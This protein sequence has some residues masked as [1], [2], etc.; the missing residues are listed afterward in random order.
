MSNDDITPQQLRDMAAQLL[1][2]AD[3]LEGQ[4]VGVASSPTPATVVHPDDTTT[5]RPSV[6]GPDTV[7]EWAAQ[8][9]DA[10]RA[11][12]LAFFDKIV[13]AGY[14][15]RDLAREESLA[16]RDAAEASAW[17]NGNFGLDDPRVQLQDAKAWLGAEQVR[18]QRDL[19]FVGLIGGPVAAINRYFHEADQLRLDKP[20]LAANYDGPLKD[21][22][23]RMMG[24]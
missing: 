20:W 18:R 4:P 17:V 22:L 10:A 12:A 11:A 6:Q 19:R 5:P 8:N 9:P 23:R 21:M 24:E 7:L 16:R 1:Q 15:P 13:Q 2:R 3:R 14:G